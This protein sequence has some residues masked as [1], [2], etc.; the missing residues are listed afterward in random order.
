M[1]IANPATV[2]RANAAATVRN[3]SKT[4]GLMPGR[5]ARGT[6]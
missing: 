3:G 5:M 1:P 2:A 6:E 4:E